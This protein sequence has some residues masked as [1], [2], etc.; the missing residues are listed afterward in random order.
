VI[1]TGRKDLS[2]LRGGYRGTLRLY[3]YS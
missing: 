2:V 1:W 3:S